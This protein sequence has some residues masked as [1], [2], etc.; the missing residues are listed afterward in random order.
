MSKYNF[1][2]VINRQGTQALKIDV[3]EERYGSP[4][5]IPLWVADMDFEAPACVKEAFIERSKHGVFGYTCPST[6][7][8]G[9][10]KEWLATQHQWM[11]D[12]QWITFIPGVVKGIA[13]VI[14]CFTEKN[15]KVII[16]PPVY[17]PFRI[18]TELHHREVLTNPL[19]FDGEQ[20]QINYEELEKM[21]QTAKLLILCNPHNPGGR[22]WSESELQ[23]I[24][25]ICHKH[26]LLVISDEIH[27]DLAFH[28]HKHVPFAHV[29]PEAEACSI[30]LMAPSKTFNVAGIVSSFAVVPNEQLRTQFW[31]YLKSSELNEGHIFAYLVA[32][33]VYEHGHEWLI[34]VKNYLWKNILWVEEYIHTHMPLLKVVR[35]QASF[36][37]WI[38]CRNLH[39]SQSRLVDFFLKEAKLALHDGAIF[40]KEGEGFMRMNIASPRS[41]LEKA[42]Q[43]LQ[44]AYQK[45]YP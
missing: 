40:G 26:N 25:A 41:I 4:E 22:V 6:Q 29:S 44:K 37:L 20:Y 7:Y 21:A 16:Q 12:E 38:D 33:T 9:S 43:Q 11:V 30:T 17:H 35:P 14:D 13:F 36:L 10:I 32:Q 2:K 15:D 34:E 31:N 39:W 27:A 8:F 3:L 19:V 24:A 18:I 42:L 5:L 23:R 1:D 28:P 45:Y